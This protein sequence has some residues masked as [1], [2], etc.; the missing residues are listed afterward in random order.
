VNDPD[1]EELTTAATEPAPPEPTVE[2]ARPFPWPPA[3]DANVILAIAETW[4]WSVFQPTTFFRAMPA[5][6]Y[7]SALGY[8]LPVAIV[9]AALHLFWSNLFEIAGVTALLPGAFA[10]ATPSATNRLIDFLLSPI[11]LPILLFVCAAIVH[12]SLKL[13]GAGSKPF[14]TTT[15]VL[16]FAYGPRLFGV[17]PFFGSIIGGIWALVLAVIGLR[18]AHG[19]STGRAATAVLLPFILVFTLLIIAGILVL[20]GAL[21]LGAK[22]LS[23]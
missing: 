6:G 9:T 3:A 22:S 17:L 12:G 14:V 8:Y 1:V 20:L 21:L 23:P 7:R 15:R 18:E 2:A 11:W 13:V 10:E 16:A 5:T 19:T 4:S